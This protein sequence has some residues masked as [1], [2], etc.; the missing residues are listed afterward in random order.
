MV[1]CNHQFN[2]HEPGQTLGDGEGQGGLACYSPWGRKASHTTGGLNNHGFPEDGLV[3]SPCC[4]RDSQESS[5]APQF[6]GI[7]SLVLC[8]FY[9]PALTTIC[10]HWENHLDYRD[11]VSRV[12]SPLFNTLSRSVIA[13][14][15]RSNC[16]LVSWL[17]S[18]STVILRSKKTNQ[19]LLLPFPLLFAM[20]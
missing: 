19:S 9:G 4:S 2:G 20:K 5:L 10:D 16:L 1:G 13:F 7:N 11:Y 18:P 15:P 17:Q 8:H 6:E 14:P 12:M 3:W